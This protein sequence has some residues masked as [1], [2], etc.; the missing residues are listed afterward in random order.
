MS[1]Q[2]TAPTHF[3]LSPDTLHEIHDRVQEIPE[4]VHELPSPHYEKSLPRL[5]TATSDSLPDR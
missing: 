1:F 2:T 3:E 5:P 4:E